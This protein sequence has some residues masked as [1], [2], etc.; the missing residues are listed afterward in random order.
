MSQTYPRS[1]Y[2]RPSKKK[3]RQG[4][5]AHGEFCQLRAATGDRRGPGDQ[6]LAAPDLP[7]LGEPVDFELS[8]EVGERSERRIVRLWQGFVMVLHQNC[9]IDF[10]HEEDSRVLV[11]P[12]VSRERWPEG[13]WG[14][15]RDN[16]LPGYLYLPGLSPEEAQELGLPAAWPESVTILASSALSSVGLIRPRREISLSQGMLPHLQDAMARFSGT[17]GFASL[18][19]LDGIAGKRIVEVTETGQTISGPSSLVKVFFGENDVEPDDRDD[20]LTIS[21]WGVRPKG[22]GSGDD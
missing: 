9:E 3:L 1:P 15:L 12:V 10:G 6:H 16:K 13:P 11:A 2:R 14:I 5:I 18:T 7:F 21:Y 8:V 17:R 4:D 20:E 19:E 22:R